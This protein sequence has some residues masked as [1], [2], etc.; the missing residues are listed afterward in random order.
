MPITERNRLSS[1]NQATFFPI[2]P[3][4]LASSIVALQFGVH[5]DAR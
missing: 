3:T 5:H 1:T 2:L 4:I